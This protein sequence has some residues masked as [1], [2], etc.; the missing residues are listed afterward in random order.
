MNSTN[1]RA[2]GAT[3]IV[4]P[5]NR[6][7]AHT[8]QLK[9][10]V[11]Q[12]TT[13]VSALSV[14]RPV[15]P[16]V[17]R[18]QQVPKVLQT[19]SSFP[20]P[21]AGQARRQPIA[22][23]VY[24]PEQKRISQPKMA[25]AAQA[26]TAPKAP[27]VYRPQPKVN[28][29]RSLPAQMKMKMAG[30]VV[31]HPQHN[32][33]AGAGRMG[34]RA[35]SHNVQAKNMHPQRSSPV[36]QRVIVIED[37]EYGLANKTQLEEAYPKEQEAMMEGM[38]RDLRHFP[39]TLDEALE[40]KRRFYLV[41]E[42]LG[43][44]GTSFFVK[45][46]DP[47]VEKVTGGFTREA[48][49]RPVLVARPESGFEEL[50]IESLI[51]CVAIIIEAQRDGQIQAAAGSHFVTPECID[52]GKLT[53]GGLRLIQGQID[54]VESYGSRNAILA[55]SHNDPQ[56]SS[57][58]VDLITQFLKSKGVASVITRQGSDRLKYQLRYDGKS[59]LSFG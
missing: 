52:E 26:H 37:K 19:K 44:F 40:E 51:S 13:G 10:I 35:A 16:P 7:A 50:R 32:K 14:K 28:A 21:H 5:F 31:S 55:H 12:L 9:P 11:A 48:G 18:P 49:K 27:P 23:P 29:Q 25:S 54:L 56:A 2:L 41:R 6:Q 17:Y 47:F 36:I 58:A 15:A 24:R 4:P 8:P 42:D 46:S 30:P 38:R 45:D 22:P 57:K 3:G 43:K 20:S 59:T 39:K 53:D 33:E 1:K 34:L